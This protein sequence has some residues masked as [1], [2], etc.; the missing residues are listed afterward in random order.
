MTGDSDH[1]DADP[2]EATLDEFTDPDWLRDRIA[3]VL[4]FYYPTCVDEERGGFV[5]QLEE[6]TG[7]VYDP[8]PRHLVASC[9][10]VAN[11]ALADRLGVADWCGPAA[12]RGL[13]FLRSAHR[14]ADGGYAWLL[15][16]TTPVDRT[17]SAYGHAFVLLAFARATAAGR[18][19]AGDGLAATA[20]LLERR[21][22]EPNGLLRSRLTPEWEPVEPYRGQNANMHACEAY[23]AA[24]EATGEAEYLERAVAIAR[25]MTVELADDRGRIWEH[26]TPDWEPDYEYNRDQPRDTFRPWGY[27]PGHHAEWAKLLARLDRHR[28]VAEHRDGDEPLGDDD[29]PHD[30][31]DD[32]LLDRAE[33]L[34]EYA[35]RG[36]DDERGGFSYTLDRDDQ[37]VVAEKYGWPVAEAVG[38]AAALYEHTGRERYLEWYDR[39]W[40]YALAQLV[41][42][43]GN[44]YTKLTP[45][46]EPVDTDDGP[47]VEPGYHPIGACY[48]GLRAFSDP[49]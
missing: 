14:E 24:H 21:F 43:G 49:D 36:W 7:A 33:A 5:A 3:D 41:A 13:A 4:G 45:G 44:W 28:T 37:P 42:P 15:D 25:R 8:A 20:D 48:E 39:L 31:D 16:G 12:D 34:F 19:G 29:W 46:N 1:S 38:A 23:L 47:A 18:P 9:R 10:F 26:Y 40:S 27:Q 11:F 6:A 32:W 35:G 2:S 17:R 22:R 30:G